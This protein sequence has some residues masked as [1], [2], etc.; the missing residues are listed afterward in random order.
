MKSGIYLYIHGSGG[1]AEAN[2]TRE[3]EK[4]LMLNYSSAK[5]RQLQNTVA[6]GGVNPRF[7][8][9]T[10]IDKKILM[11]L[12]PGEGTQK[13]K[14][15]RARDL[16]VFRGGSAINELNPA[17]LAYRMTVMD[18]TNQ[19]VAMDPGFQLTILR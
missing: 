16:D 13:E 11:A 12:A 18:T 9:M 17:G 19:R 2:N 14:I 15:A 7:G 3:M 4:R 6:E 10:V 5:R 1:Y 8:S